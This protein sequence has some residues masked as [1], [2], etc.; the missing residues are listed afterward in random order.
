MLHEFEGRWL[1]C[2]SDDIPGMVPFAGLRGP[3]SEK[4]TLL[5]SGPTRLSCVGVMLQGLLRM[6]RGP[7]LDV[8]K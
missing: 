3:G 5:L 1:D 2:F 7:A 8:S 6:L 4:P